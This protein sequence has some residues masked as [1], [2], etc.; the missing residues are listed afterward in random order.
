MHGGN[1]MGM[2]SMNVWSILGIVVVIGVLWL[3]F[4][5]FG[6]GKPPGGSP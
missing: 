1:G 4:K 6:Q 5:S 3:V 2:G